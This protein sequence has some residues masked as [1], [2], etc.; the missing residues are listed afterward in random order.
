M[1]FYTEQDK[2]LTYIIDRFLMTSVQL[3]NISRDFLDKNEFASRHTFTY[4]N[5][6]SLV[7][8]RQ[9]RSTMEMSTLKT[10]GYELYW[11]YHYHCCDISIAN[12]HLSIVEN[13]LFLYCS[14]LNMHTCRSIDIRTTYKLPPIE[15]TCVLL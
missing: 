10:Y 5:V 14:H 7:S 1:T 6:R 13:N 12:V 11:S 15:H 8:R 9:F 3:P 4:R 2:R